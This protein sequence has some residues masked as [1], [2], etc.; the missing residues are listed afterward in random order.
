MKR[1]ALRRLREQI[2]GLFVDE[3]R[4]AAE[5]AALEML[6]SWDPREPDATFRNAD[7]GEVRIQLK[8][9]LPPEGT[10]LR[11]AAEML[12]LH[13]GPLHVEEIA[14]RLAAAGVKVSKASLAASLDRRARLGQGFQRQL[15]VPNTFLFDSSSEA[16]P[17]KARGRRGRRRPR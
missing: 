12:I 16:V 2:R 10:V 5:V 17:A 13:G 8:A 1:R 15:N 9:D 3:Q 7:G 14:A 4:L 6:A 11:R